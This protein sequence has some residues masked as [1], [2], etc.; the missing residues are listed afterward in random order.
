MTDLAVTPS[1]QGGAVLEIEL[2]LAP[3][4]A[5]EYLLELTTTGEGGEIKELLGF[6]VT[7]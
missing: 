3:I 2:P 4:A 5:G 1:A 6:R 7:G